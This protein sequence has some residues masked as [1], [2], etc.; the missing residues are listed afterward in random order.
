MM[1]A[2]HRRLLAFGLAL[3]AGTSGV[4]AQPQRP[5]RTSKLSLK[6]LVETVPAASVRP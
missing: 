1:P 2:P 3:V 5:V 4:F 6:R